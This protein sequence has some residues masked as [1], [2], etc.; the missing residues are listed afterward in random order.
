MG[1]AVNRMKRLLS[2]SWIGAVGFGLLGLGLYLLKP[3]KWIWITVAEVAALVCLVAFFVTYFE[4]FKEVSQ[5]RATRF[6]ANSTLMVLLFLAILG[7]INL[8]LNRHYLRADLTEAGEFSLASQTVQVLKTLRDREIQITG[9]FQGDSAQGQRFAELVQSYQYHAPK[10][11]YTAVDPDRNPA[12]AR[13]YR[14]QFYGTV[15]VESEGQETRI[16]ETTEEALTNAIL[17]VTRKG[18]KT[19]YFLEGHGEHG[20]DDFKQ[21]GYSQ[22]KE[23]LENQHFVVKSLLLLKEGRVPEDAAVVVIGGPTKPFHPKEIEAL[24]AYLDQGGQV[25]A[26]ADPETGDILDDL[27]EPWGIRLGD[28]LVIDTLSR[29]FGGDYAI[30]VVNEYPY[31]EITRDFRVATFFPG[32]RSVGFDTSRE[33]RLKFRPLAKT[34]PTAWAERDWR[35]QPVRFDQGRDRKG[36]VTVAGIVVRKKPRDAKEET[37]TPGGKKAGKPD[38]PS[39][40]GKK[41]QGR[42][43]VFGDSDFA[44]NGYFRFSGNGDLFLNAVSWLAE[45]MDLVA[46]R[47]KEAKSTPLFLT[48]TQGRLLFWVSVV[49]VP[50]TVVGAGIGVWR[51]RKRL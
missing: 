41:R 48:A 49:L 37:Q 31:H 15:V 26:M 27:L 25:V 44:A 28:D 21:T 29:L 46:I 12:T 24:K 40:T 11:R 42:L 33:D 2:Y 36:P 4:V 10:I 1:E 43:V 7:M 13:R 20:L 45:E 22:A 30:P 5:R 17:K 34:S 51:W 35:R 8:L 9:F 16:R 38:S 18:K 6:G 39:G 14:I 19:I 47:P 50:V 23:E 3:E 32:T